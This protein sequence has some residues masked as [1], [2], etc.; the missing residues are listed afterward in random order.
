MRD[1][2]MAEYVII[3]VSYSD[4]EEHIEWVRVAREIANKRLLD[5]S[6][7]HR[8]FIVDLLKTN[9]ASFKTAI[10]T[11]N[12]AN[13]TYSY[14]TGADVHVISNQFLATDSN[15]TKSDNL[16]NLPRFSMPNEEITKSADV[17]FD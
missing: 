10:V 11:T 14:R 1:I 6:V 9:S 2:N 4:K 16:S 3:G 8:S 13:K 15:A 5:A 7:V 17:I 12:N